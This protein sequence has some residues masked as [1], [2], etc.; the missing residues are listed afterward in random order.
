VK[1]TFDA[2]TNPK[3]DI[4]SRHGYDIVRSVET[5][6]PLTVV[7]HLKERFAPFVSA[8][9]G[10]SDSPYAILPA[11]V[12]AKFANLNN[13]P[14]NSA[15]MGTGPFKFVRWIRG[16]RIKFVRNERYFI[17]RPKIE[18]VIWRLIPDENT[19]MQLLRTHE[20]DWMYEA[21]VTA[22]KA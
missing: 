22:Y 19:E 1:F 5:P 3:N 11:H 6:D 15:P 12:L 14:Y 21:S 16:D 10:E 8:V 13:V 17:G 20:A 4:I 9:F 2:I 7:F 18:R